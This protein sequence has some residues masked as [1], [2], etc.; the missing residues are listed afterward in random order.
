MSSPAAAVAVA[1]AL[2]GW[3]RLVLTR[4]PGT[5]LALFRAAVGACVLI[6]LG[7]VIWHGDVAALWFAP[8]NG[9]YHLPNANWT[10]SLLG[11]ADPLR[12][13]AVLGCTLA[14]G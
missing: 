12:I 1:P 5:T 11:G 8:A 10:F 7:S 6:S 2:P 14:A 13:R 3:A 4:E 9:G